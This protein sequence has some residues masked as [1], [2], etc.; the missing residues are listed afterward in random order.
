MSEYSEII[1]QLNAS[2]AP[3]N[4]MWAGNILT[5]LTFRSL[6]VSRAD[7]FKVAHKLGRT[8]SA[9]EYMTQLIYIM[10]SIGT[11][12]NLQ[13]LFTDLI[14]A[15][16]DK[17][18]VN[19]IVNLYS[20]EQAVA[21]GGGLSPDTE[22]KDYNKLHKLVLKYVELSK[23]GKV[24]TFSDFFRYLSSG[25][26]FMGLNLLI[27]K[28]GFLR[29]TYPVMICGYPL[30]HVQEIEVARS[31][32]ILKFRADGSVFLANQEG[33]ED[34]VIVKCLILP[35]ELVYTIMT[36]WRIFLYGR[37]NVREVGSMDANMFDVA[38]LRAKI[39]DVTSYDPSLKKPS[40]EFHRTFPLV[41]RH[42]I[43]P[44]IYIETLGFEDR[45]VD[46]KDV[47][48]CSILCRTYRKPRV[49]KMYSKD[50]SSSF[51]TSSPN[52]NTKLYAMLEWS[53]NTV[54]RYINSLGIV[55]DERTWKTGVDATGQDD[56]YYNIK[57]QDVAMSFMLGAFGVLI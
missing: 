51:F 27:K 25:I 30:P 5:K 32:K 39:G 8:D 36:L 14:N 19:I 47:I 55:F 33:G 12:I 20:P 43:I 4:E 56:I 37:M 13:D 48:S 17:E 34:A 41:S 15:D 6:T 31:G 23:Q 29:Y 18:F 16:E 26:E 7:A 11:P 44:N 10:E 46:G 52:T 57:P 28:T 40:Y 54:W 24:L 45:I 9:K 1:T 50:K 38:E 2:S 21:I 3:Y 42:V 49:F 22:S 35:D 53:M